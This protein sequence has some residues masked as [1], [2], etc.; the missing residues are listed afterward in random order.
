[1]CRT[2]HVSPEHTC[3]HLYSYLQHRSVY[4]YLVAIDHISV[5]LPSCGKVFHACTLNLKATSQ[6]NR[7]TRYLRVFSRT[8]TL[9]ISPPFRCRVRSFYTSSITG[10]SICSNLQGN[11]VRKP[12]PCE[13]NNTAVSG[14]GWPYLSSASHSLKAPSAGTR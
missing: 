3:M 4:F 6:S 7:L 12:M 14:F 1:M 8:L 10:F 2:S 5:L 9:S 13:R 11:N